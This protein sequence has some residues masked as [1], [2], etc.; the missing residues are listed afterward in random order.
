MKLQLTQNALAGSLVGIG[1]S[2]PN[3]PPVPALGGVVVHADRDVVTLSAFDYEVS[4]RSVA[5]ATTVSEPGSVLVSGKL[6]NEITR[7]LPATR[8]VE[9]FTDDTYL[10]V[11]CDEIRFTL[12]A[13][14]IEDYPALPDTPAIAGTTTLDDFTEAVTQV[15]VAAGRDDTIPMLTGI[16]I[17]RHPTFLRFVA[18]DR[19]RIAIRDIGWQPTG[20]IDDEAQRSGLVVA[21]RTLA[22]AAKAFTGTEIGIAAGS[23]HTVLGLR[24]TDQHCTLALLDL[25]FVPYQRYLENIGTTTATIDTSAFINAV[26]RVSLLS[27]RGNQIL[28]TFTDS[29]VRLRAGA[30]S[31]GRAEESLTCQT[32]GDPGPIAFNPRYLL[33]GLGAIH[34]DTVTITMNGPTKAATIRSADSDSAGLR[35]IVMPVRPPS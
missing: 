13:M 32:T 9:L 25:E 21:A 28:L 14:P 27:P 3:R 8:P 19:F 23:V 16:K 2:I 35:Y 29:A 31:N 1:H 10:H 11:V 17:E 5:T 4:A 26:K 18:T 12:P 24:T 30:D 34:A 20:D 7:S 33:D 6:L 22:G 15:V